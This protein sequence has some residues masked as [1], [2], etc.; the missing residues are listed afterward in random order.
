MVHSYKPVLMKSFLRRLPEL[1]FP[2]DG[3]AEEFVAFYQDRAERGLVVEREGCVF[4][5]S[6]G[7]AEDL[8]RE[9]ARRIVKDVFW[10]LNR[11]ARLVGTRCCLQEEAGWKG[12]M[13]RGA[14]PTATRAC[15]TAL[16]AY[17]RRLQ[18]TGDALYVRN[19]KGESRAAEMV[20]HL[21]DPDE[22]LPLLRLRG[23]NE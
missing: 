11:V 7:V 14:L 13:E 15:D 12:F 1:V 16:E 3:V 9:T 18:S 17:F 2:F 23:S 22:E 20:F 8:G 6:H 5:T 19:S 10:R 21:S 4:V